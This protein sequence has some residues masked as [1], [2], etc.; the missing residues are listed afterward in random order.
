MIRGKESRLKPELRLLKGLTNCDALER[1][2]TVAK[3]EV[4]YATIRVVGAAEPSRP[5]DRRT[6]HGR[7]LA[8]WMHAR[9]ASLRARVGRSPCSYV[10]EPHWAGA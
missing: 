10:A 6:G 1:R 5:S 7:G 3:D 9:Y 8:L 4:I 2:S